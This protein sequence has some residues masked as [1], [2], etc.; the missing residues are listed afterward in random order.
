MQ[1]SYLFPL[2]P[3]G[4]CRTG[5]RTW[6]ELSRASAVIVALAVAHGESLMKKDAESGFYS[7]ML[8]CVG[9]LPTAEIS[10]VSCGLQSGRFV[11]RTPSAPYS[12]PIPGLLRQNFCCTNS[13]RGCGPS[14]NIASSKA[15][16]DF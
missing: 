5:Y 12:R 2:E 16:I 10:K 7:Y 9:R 3:S 6:Q 15:C 13:F 1:V 8:I 4:H 14:V 11:E